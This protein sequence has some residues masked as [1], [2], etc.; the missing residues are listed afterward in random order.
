GGGGG[1]G[2]PGRGGRL[3]PGGPPTLGHGRSSLSCRTLG[4]RSTTRHSGGPVLSREQ[5]D[6]FVSTSEIMSAEPGNRA[7]V[8]TLWLGKDGRTAGAVGLHAVG[9]RCRFRIYRPGRSLDVAA[10]GLWPPVLGAVGVRG[11]R[12]GSGGTRAG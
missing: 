9:A 4:R 1:R 3:K 5:E 10:G 8:V 12:D 7:D 11:V 6:L 2:G